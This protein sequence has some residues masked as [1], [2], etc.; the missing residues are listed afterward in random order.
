M[1]SALRQVAMPIETKRV[2][3]RP[4]Q[5]VTDL[6]EWFARVQQALAVDREGDWRAEGTMLCAD[7]SADE[8]VR[9]LECVRDTLGDAVV[10]GTEEV[11]D[12]DVTGGVRSL[13][14]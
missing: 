5:D 7:L 6:D 12:V 14:V 9:I 3:L 8:A 13:V 11:V 1:P 2:V 4:A 10:A